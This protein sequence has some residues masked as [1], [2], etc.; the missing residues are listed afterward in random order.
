MRKLI[1]AAAAALLMGHA[2]NGFAGEF[3]YE[4][5]SEPPSVQAALE[6][7]IDSM[8]RLDVQPVE[9]ARTHYQAVAGS[10]STGATDCAC[11]DRGRH[12]AHHRVVY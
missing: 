9:R 1:T 11:T 12:I 2:G 6:Q 8:L 5:A 4:L 3:A 10:G 7:M